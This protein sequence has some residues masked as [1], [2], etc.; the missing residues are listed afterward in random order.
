MIGALDQ[1]DC[2]QPPAVTVTALAFS[3]SRLPA[4][5]V[6]GLAQQSK[7]ACAADM[8][9]AAFEAVTGALVTAS[10]VHHRCRRA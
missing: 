3:L 9:A 8:S 5:L 7:S 2:R 10:P 1:E 4:G 6:N